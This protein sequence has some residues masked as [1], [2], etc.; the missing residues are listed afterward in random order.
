MPDYIAMRLE[1]EKD[2]EHYGVKGQ[3]WGVRRSSSQLRAAAKVNPPIKQV[4]AKK[5]AASNTSAKKPA[6]DSPDKAESPAAR[7]ARLAAQ[8]KE[9]KASDMDEQDLRFFNARTDALKK[10]ESLN[11]TKPGWLRETTT[12]VV[13]QSG[14]RL[15]QNVTDTL[16]DKYF[17]D[18]LK[19]AIKGKTEE[20]VEQAIQRG[21]SEALRKKAIEDGIKKITG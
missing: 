3:Q 14:Q 9:G 15:M 1:E 18:P 16:T 5:A 2:A 13:Q 4:E 6:G 21:A 7:Y 8:A 12:K 19:A 11:E 10:V 20:T 17:V